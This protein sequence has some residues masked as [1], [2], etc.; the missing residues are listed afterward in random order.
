MP[1]PVWGWASPGGR[2]EVSIAGASARAVAGPDGRWCARLPSLPAGGPHV[3]RAASAAGD[4][5]VTD[6]LIGDVWLCS[7]QSNMEMTLAATAQE[8]PDAADLPDLRLLTLATPAQLGRQEAI[9]GR[10]IRADPAALAAFSAVGG[11]FGR[12]MHRALGVP[13][14]LICNAWGGTRIQAWISREAL[15]Q[16]PQGAE[17]I[18]RYEAQRSAAA[19]PDHAADLAAW[20]RDGRRLDSPDRR[21]ADGWAASGFDDRDWATMPLPRRWQDHGHAGSGIFWFRRSIAVPPGWAGRDLTLRL[22]AIDKHDDTFVA[23]ERIGGMSWE[24]GPDTWRTPRA[25]TVPSRLVGGARLDIAV[26]V[27]SHAFHGGLTGPAAA[28]GIHP[29]DEPGAAIALAGRWRYRCE[30]DWGVRLPPAPPWGAGNKNSP[31]IQFDSRVAPLIPYAIR[32]VLWYQGESNTGDPAT[33]RRLL[34]RLIRDWRSAWGQG[35]F[36]VLLAQL[37]SHHQPHAEPCTSA[38]AAIREAQLAALAEPA[39]GLAVTI[40]AGDADDIHPRDK[41]TVGLRLARWALADIHGHGGEPSGP[42]YLGMERD[43]CGRLRCHF[44]FAAGLRTADRLAPTCV[45]IA[46]EDRVFVRAQTMIEGDMLVAWSPEIAQPAAVRYA[47]A[48]NPAGCNLVNGAGLPAS[49]FRSDDW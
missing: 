23:G 42:L 49:P 12:E 43:P 20:E 13:V 17:E 44:R 33:Y 22:G 35:D 10:W 25:Y 6:I 3:L 15:L 34:P 39:T 46:G 29:A 48:D 40:D 19:V 1:I 21:L 7:G 41:R 9:D 18:P 16:D 2:V 14:G 47:W 4:R 30:A 8:M 24:D 45:D 37:T 31:H 36:P 38:W 11:W 26:R 27:R 28:M 5:S 32:G